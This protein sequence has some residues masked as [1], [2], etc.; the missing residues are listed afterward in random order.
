[1]T[2]SAAATVGGGCDF[3]KYIHSY[4]HTQKHSLMIISAA[5]MTVADL[6]PVCKL[7]VHVSACHILL[8][9]NQSLYFYPSVQTDL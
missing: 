7:S 4:I 3:K 6:S 5:E 1:M 2:K 8:R 9:S